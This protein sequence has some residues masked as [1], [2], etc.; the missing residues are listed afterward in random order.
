M[1]RRSY[2]TVKGFEIRNYTTDSE[3]DVP[4]GVWI[5]GSGTGIRILN[6]RVHNIATTSE[7]NGNAF[8]ISAYG[9][10]KTPITQL[11]ISGNEV[12]DLRTGKANR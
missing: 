7:K 3:N 5:T 1:G 11:V 8:G 6:N 2:I 4:S 10:S 9:T 12:Y